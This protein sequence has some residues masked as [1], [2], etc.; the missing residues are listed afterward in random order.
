MNFC[1]GKSQDE[2]IAIARSLR[3]LAKLS[4][5]SNVESHPCWIAAD[6]IEDLVM[7]LKEAKEKND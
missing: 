4:H 5:K 3:K 1:A 7:E 2:I 6:V